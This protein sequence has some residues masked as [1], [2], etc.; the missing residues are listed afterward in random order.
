MRLIK[1]KNLNNYKFYL[2]FENQISGEVNLEKLISKHLSLVELASVNL[3]KKRGCLEFK[4][5]M[6]DIEPKTL[7]KFF[8]FHEL[9][10]RDK[11]QSTTRIQKAP[12]QE[13]RS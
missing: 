3:N 13:I 12:Q 1:Y 11:Y 2:E 4:D 10:T 9:L 7:Y 5:G 8:K 6:V